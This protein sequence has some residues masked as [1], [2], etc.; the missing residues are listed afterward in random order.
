M[1]ES[2][3][4]PE[5]L[6]MTNRMLA[7]AGLVATVRSLKDI[8]AVCSS[9]S[10]FVAT[11][12]ALIGHRLEGVIRRPENN[13]QRAKNCDLVV[14][15]LSSR[16]GTDLSHIS[17]E[18]VVAGNL[19]DIRDLVEILS[20]LTHMLPL[21]AQ[22]QKVPSAGAAGPADHGETSKSVAVAPMPAAAQAELPGEAG[23]PR[24]GPH[25]RNEEAGERQPYLAA[26]EYQPAPSSPPEQIPVQLPLRNQEL[27]SPHSPRPSGGSFM[28]S[29]GSTP[30]S[31]RRRRRRR[32]HEH[33]PPAPP[34]TPARLPIPQRLP[35]EMAAELAG[36][37]QARQR[38]RITPKTATDARRRQL[39]ETAHKASVKM[40]GLRRHPDEPRDA[41][42]RARGS[43]DPAQDG[44]FRIPTHSD[45]SFRSYNG[46]GG[47]AADWA[48]EG[49][50][51]EAASVGTASVRS[52]NERQQ[53]WQRDGETPSDTLSRDEGSMSETAEYGTEH[54][55]SQVPGGGE[56]GQADPHDARRTQPLY[57]ADGASMDALD[58]E[59][60]MEDEVPVG[61]WSSGQSMRRPMSAPQTAQRKTS[62]QNVTLAELKRAVNVPAGHPSTLRQLSGRPSSSRQ[63]DPHWKGLEHAQASR[64]K[65][66]KSQRR[67]EAN[68][69]AARPA[70]A[71]QRAAPLPESS[72]FS[73]GVTAKAA[74]AGGSAVEGVQVGK[75]SGPAVNL[76]SA[77]LDPSLARRMA[78][79][80]DMKHT[81]GRTARHAEA[82]SR[83][84]VQAAESRVRGLKEVW[85]HKR[86]VEENQ[87]IDKLQKKEI[88]ESRGRRHRREETRCFL[89]FFLG[90]RIGSALTVGEP[91]EPVASEKVEQL[92]AERFRRKLRDMEHS[93]VLRRQ[94]QEAALFRNV[95]LEAVEREKE[96]V[97][98]ERRYAR[99]HREGLERKEMLHQQRVESWYREQS[100]M[101]EENIQVARKEKVWQQKEHDNHVR[102]IERE[103]AEEIERDRTNVLQR[104]DHEENAAYF[105]MMDPARISGG[106]LR[107][108]SNMMT[109]IS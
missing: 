31:A 32:I 87:D 86:A 26:E 104:I 84:R 61:R 54:S 77:E 56:E 3:N 35:H 25:A 105:H 24:S 18:N 109:E 20:T 101:L 48:E 40:K 8:E 2:L 80:I 15:Q 65:S 102:M 69:A 5:L 36:Q 46:L 85:K 89:M 73:R 52:E 43:H 99:E 16:L 66:H 53:A 9:T 96:K 67:A 68:A 44:P 28:Q 10:I 93:R 37:R 74:G 55:E 57:R 4:N 97:L 79:V 38:M 98:E 82:R 58:E 22:G 30:K 83:K 21:P 95:F 13:A 11:C 64:L 78:H 1:P 23:L 72:H 14:A 47:G 90:W 106:L 71:R 33:V 50:S 88:L 62:S 34:T 6:A 49:P 100:K 92:R 7:A 42:G 76:P 12:E 108:I 51:P 107:K 75:S 59:A 39:I 63:K 60:E 94:N 41:E 81:S 103:K 19:G 91:A 27:D 17:G 70:S 29:V 45:T